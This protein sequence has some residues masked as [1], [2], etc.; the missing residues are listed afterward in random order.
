MPANGENVM[1]LRASE[2]VEAGML[3]D[4]KWVGGAK[5]IEVRNPAHPSEVV[6][7]IVRATP[8]DVDKAVAAAKAAQSDWAKKT[9]TERAAILAKAVDCLEHEIAERAMLFVRE[10][11][12]VLDDAKGEVGGAPKRLRLMLELA[13]DLDA[14]RVVEAPNG[15]SWV[16][17]LPY[18]VV[19]SIVPWNSPI[20]LGFMQVF[21][22][23]LAGNAVVLKPPESCPLALIR[24]VE[25]IADVLPAGT[26]NLVTGMP[27]EIGNALTGHPDVGKIGFTGSVASARKI[28]A[29]A[30]G[31][32]KGLTF[33]L[34]GNDA[35]I[36]LDDADLSPETM[37]R[38]CR[39]VFRMTGQICMAI[40]RIY[41]QEPLAEKFIKAFTA[42]ANEIVVGDGL[43]EGV[44]MGPLHRAVARDNARAYLSDARER[45]GEVL[46]VGRVDNQATFDEGYFMRPAI[47]TGLTDDAPL[48]A[49]EQFCA[50]IPILTFIEVDDA[51]AR[52]N[53]SI[54]GLGGSVWST[55]Q[56]RGL[57]VASRMETATVFVNTHGTESINRRLPYGG[58]KQS[59]I[60]C[61]SGIEGIREYLQVRTIT[62][63][64]F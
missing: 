19:V 26:L 58:V 41:V 5:R 38:L 21:S 48:V 32:V 50:A 62:T 36:V 57:A 31:T 11:G 7:T 45:G 30:A 17:D 28:M 51:I 1:D 44:T 33:E 43:V 55:D 61:K 59:G 52:A 14:E 24:S 27:D 3:I 4:G 40:K 53:A 46:E 47:V 56:A 10:N 16:K 63:F 54:Y 34:G 20:S 13:A 35:A 8:D 29:H 9:F 25:L 2:V 15:R 12:K 37:R 60:G 18:G 42:A 49:D 6:G 23:L 64:D 22:A 39:S